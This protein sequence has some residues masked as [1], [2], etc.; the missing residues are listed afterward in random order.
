MLDLTLWIKSLN[1]IEEK[2]ASFVYSPHIA[3]I[4]LYTEV[5]TN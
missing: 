3:F 4:D 2:M 1:Y 5:M